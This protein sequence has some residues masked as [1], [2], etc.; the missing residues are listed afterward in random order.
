MQVVCSTGDKLFNSL[1][2]INNSALN[3]CSYVLE[4]DTSS[5]YTDILSVSVSQYSSDL[6]FALLSRDSW[7]ERP[8]TSGEPAGSVSGDAGTT[9]PLTLPQS[10]SQ[11]GSQSTLPVWWHHRHSACM[12]TLKKTF[13]TLN[14]ILI[15]VFSLLLEL[16]CDWKLTFR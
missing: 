16:V 5:Y 4:S 2:D 15:V 7:V 6:L 11:V 9:H 8:R 12:E 3:W 1:L 14:L 13:I 10:T